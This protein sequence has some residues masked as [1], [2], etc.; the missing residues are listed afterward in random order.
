M[1]DSYGNTNDGNTSRRFFSDPDTAS[2][3]TGIDI[4][5]IRRLKVI[6]ETLSSSHSIYTE[7]FE[8]YAEDTAKLYVELYC[9]YPMTPTLHKILRHGALVIK[10]TIVPI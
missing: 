6:L 3:I 8:K 4:N 1:M 9:W 10:N 5:L 7:K 2:D